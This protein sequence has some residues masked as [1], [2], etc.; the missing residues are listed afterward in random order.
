M[1]FKAF[2]GRS[3][4]KQKYLKRLCSH[5]IAEQ[6]LQGYGFWKNCKGSA[7]G[8]TV[9][10]S[11]FAAYE[12][13]L[14][15]PAQ[16]A[17]LVDSFF[18]SISTDMSKVWPERF[19]SAIPV[20]ANLSLIWTQFVTW[21]LLD[22]GEGVIQFV[23]TDD[24]RRAIQ[25]VA[26]LYN[27]GC[28]DR[29][30]WIAAGEEASFY[31]DGRKNIP[32]A[33]RALYAAVGTARLAAHSSIAALGKNRSIEEAGYAIQLKGYY[34]GKAVDEAASAVY[35]ATNATDTVAVYERWAEKLLELLAAAPL[36]FK[37]V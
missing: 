35:W 25:Q 14:G 1:E 8:C 7:V 9:H 21:L 36:N 23:E 26:G 13:E 18:E 37:Q 28:T 24:E 6:I 4:T 5:M 19:L 20:G 10:G 11:L 32:Y 30:R 27:T 31:F 29:M 12:T 16:L 17:G 33:T 15:I 3:A 22:A 2:H 34:A